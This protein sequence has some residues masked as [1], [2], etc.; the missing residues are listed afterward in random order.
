MPVRYG[1]PPKRRKSAFRS[2]RVANDDDVCVPVNLST[3]AEDDAVSRAVEDADEV[4]LSTCHSLPPLPTGDA[5]VAA[6]IK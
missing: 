3:V 5:A 6:F 2:A 1:R 4:T